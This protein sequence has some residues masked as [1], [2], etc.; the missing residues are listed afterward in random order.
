M[1]LAEEVWCEECGRVVRALHFGR[2]DRCDPDATR[3]EEEAS[4]TW[5]MSNPEDVAELERLKQAMKRARLVSNA[6]RAKAVEG[7]N[8]PGHKL[9]ERGT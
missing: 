6:L 8:K 9:K 7:D 4:T 2:C 5:D 3:D 1:P